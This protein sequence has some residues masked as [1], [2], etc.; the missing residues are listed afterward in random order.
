M[1]KPRSLDSI[2]EE[3]HPAQQAGLDVAGEG[4][5]PVAPPPSTSD[6]IRHMGDSDNVGITFVAEPDPGEVWSLGD[7]RL[8]QGADITIRPSDFHKMRAGYACLRC[9][10]PQDESFPLACSMCGYSMRELQIRDIAVEFSGTKHL[11][12]SK[13]VSDYVDA[14]DEEAEKKKFAKRIYEGGSIR[15][16]R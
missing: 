4:A 12:P 3:L 6:L 9:L 14:L 7:D 10:E 1:R 16:K 8:M 5:A 2:I 15:R 13:P 11:G